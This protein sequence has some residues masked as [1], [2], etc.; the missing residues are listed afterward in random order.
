M[1]CKKKYVLLSASEISHDVSEKYIFCGHLPS[2]EIASS[3]HFL[4]KT[5]FS[6]LLPP[7]GEV[8]ATPTIGDKKRVILSA[9]EISH[10]LSEKYIHCGNL[11]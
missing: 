4:A 2:R 1:T 10:D 5:E 7:S 6:Y 8:S 11:Q 9:S 3:F